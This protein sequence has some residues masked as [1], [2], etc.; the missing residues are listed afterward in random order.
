MPAFSALDGVDR[1]SIAA[2]PAFIAAPA[3]DVASLVGCSYAGPMSRLAAPENALIVVVRD[4]QVLV[5]EVESIP[6]LPTVCEVGSW[7]TTDRAPE[8]VGRFESSDVYA[9]AADENEFTNDRLRFVPVRSLFGTLEAKLLDIVGRSLSI[10]EFE[11]THRFC[12]RCGSVTEPIPGERGKRCARCGFTFYPRIA[13]A[14]ITLIEHENRLLLAR[15][16]RFK[17]GLFS[18]VAGFVEIGESL[19]QAAAREVREEVGVE[20]RD[21]RYFG[22]QPWPFGR[23]LMIGYF[24]RYAGGEIQVDGTEIVEA[25]WFDLEHLPLL[26]PPLSIA[27]QLIDAFIA[28]Q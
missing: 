1:C 20:I 27:R 28:Q 7:L 10:A 12:G 17:T 8:L 26:P 18:A 25:R 22:S 9:L 11:V 13:P 2:R 23:S 19:E 24:A 14:V 21:L 5:L 3:R 6:R 15:S 16:A 4:A